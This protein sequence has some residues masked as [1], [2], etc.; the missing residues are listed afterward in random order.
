[1]IEVEARHA[2]HPDHAKGMD[3]AMLRAFPQV[4]G[5]SRQISITR[6]PFVPPLRRLIFM[7]Q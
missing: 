5:S 2:I 7:V 6:R 4:D 1:M 3:T